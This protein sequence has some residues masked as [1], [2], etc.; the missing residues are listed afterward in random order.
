VA[1]RVAFLVAFLVARRLVTRVAAV[2]LVE[3]D[4][5]PDFFGEIF[6]SAISV[7]PP[8]FPAPW[9]VDGPS[10]SGYPSPSR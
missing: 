7:T 1:F 10:V 6:F 8:R 9:G 4:F 3:D 5:D 2:R